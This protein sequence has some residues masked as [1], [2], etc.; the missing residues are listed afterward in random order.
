VLGGLPVSTV[1]TLIL[2]P[3]LSR[4]VMGRRSEEAGPDT[5]AGLA[6]AAASE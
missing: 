4:P 1:F 6:V 3:L 2:V 5:S